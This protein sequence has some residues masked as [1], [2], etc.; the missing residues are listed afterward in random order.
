M[1]NK[2]QCNACDDVVS[3]DQNNDLSCSCSDIDPISIDIDD[4]IPKSWKSED[5]SGYVC[6][7]CEI[8]PYVIRVLQYDTTTESDLEVGNVLTCDHKRHTV[9]FDAERDLPDRWSVQSDDSE[10]EVYG[11]DDSNSRLRS[12]S[13]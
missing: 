4:T 5:T 6:T 1:T 12:L 2:L 9:I 13:D 11:S 7:E 10:D 8:R 3:I